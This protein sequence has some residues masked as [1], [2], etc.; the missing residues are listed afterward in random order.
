MV[1]LFKRKGAKTFT[2]GWTDPETGE[3]RQ[4]STK[5]R[6]EKKANKMK[7]DLE[8]ALSKSSKA[9]P[10][11][12]PKRGPLVAEAVAHWLE[13][14]KRRG[15][16]NWPNEEAHMRLHL[17]PVLGS[18]P[19][20]EVRVRHMREFVHDLQQKVPGRGKGVD[21]GTTSQ[22][23]RRL[24]PRTVRRIWGT[25]HKFFQDMT[26]DE[27][28]PTNPCQVAPDDLPPDVDKDPEWR[29][30]ALFAVPEVE[31]FTSDVRIPESRRMRYAL[32]FLTGSRFGEAAG[33]RFRHIDPDH[34][35]LQRLLIA[36]SYGGY[37]KTVV[38]KM[39]PIHPVLLSMLASWKLGGYERHTGR[40]WTDDDFIVP[41]AEGR[42]EDRHRARKDHLIDL[43]VLGLRHRR[44]H[45]TRRTFIS[46][47]RNARVDRS[48]VEKMTHAPRKSM[49]D[50]YTTWEWEAVC[51]AVLMIK[52]RRGCG[53]GASG[54][55]S[56]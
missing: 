38:T 19:I 17:L 46:M 39:I 34:E 55:G 33:L 15:K 35:P 7:R 5:T 29:A 26:L 22:E 31:S 6:D 32:M 24:A 48:L 16:S 25:V 9:D 8:R 45:D 53:S 11:V 3:W 2:L 36:R 43:K 21:A 44:M 47:L 51:E 20:R 10:I 52:L 28:I 37:T 56:R 50:I 12:R 1:S 18:A 13:V 40:R 27:V 41:K 30:T 4:A 49:I 14:R 42:M 54:T 23:D